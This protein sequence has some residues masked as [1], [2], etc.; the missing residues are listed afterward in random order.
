MFPWLI[1]KYHDA[2]CNTDDIRHVLWEA[3]NINQLQILEKDK[4][5]TIWGA[6]FDMTNI[7]RETLLV[8]FCQQLQWYKFLNAGNFNLETFILI[9]QEVVKNTM[10][11]GTKRS[12]FIIEETQKRL[13]FIYRDIGWKW[14]LTQKAWE[15]E[16]NSN[17][18]TSLLFGASDTNITLFDSKK[19]VFKENDKFHMIDCPDVTSGPMYIGDIQVKKE[20]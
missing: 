1:N 9:V 14:M 10:D 7:E 15:Y 2:Q 12:I 17:L 3:W 16:T 5:H 18:W 20:R 6:L 19:I 11:H 13:R 8:S 4:K